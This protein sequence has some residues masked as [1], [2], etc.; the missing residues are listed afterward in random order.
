ME[1]GLYD[2]KLVLRFIISITKH[3][4][5]LIKEMVANK[6]NYFVLT[7][8]LP[9]SFSLLSTKDIGIIHGHTLYKTYSKEDRLDS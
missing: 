6:S 7:S 8:F 3:H 1:L 5:T 9:F 4:F 2:I